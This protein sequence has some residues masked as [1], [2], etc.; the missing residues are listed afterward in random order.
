MKMTI[1]AFAF[2]LVMLIG[3]QGKAQ[4]EKTVPVVYTVYYSTSTTQLNENNKKV[5]NP[6]PG[7]FECDE[8]MPS[9]NV[10]V[11]TCFNGDPD[12][13]Q[14]AILKQDGWYYPSGLSKFPASLIPSHWQ[15]L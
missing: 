6:L 7:W 1:K 11:R 10:L 14:K 15:N 8:V 13:A 4:K 9:L 5:S 3:F 12:D 2:A